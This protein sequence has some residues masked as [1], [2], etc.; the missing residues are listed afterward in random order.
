MEIE[1]NKVTI[2]E[3]E[4]QAVVTLKA[5]I[6]DNFAEN[7]FSI[8]SQNIIGK[9]FERLVDD[10]HAKVMSEKGPEVLGAITINQLANAI[11]MKAGGF[12]K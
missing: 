5:F 3:K 8:T 11:L 1:I 4:I 7:R 6:N 10:L 9:V 12:S 2:D